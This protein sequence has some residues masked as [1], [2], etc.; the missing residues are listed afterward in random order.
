LTEALNRKDQRI[1]KL[2]ADLKAA[3]QPAARTAAA[4]RKY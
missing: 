3:T 4:A 1:T 2:E